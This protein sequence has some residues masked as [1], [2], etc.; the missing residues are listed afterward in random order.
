MSRA[1]GQSITE[2][3]S[4]ASYLLTTAHGPDGKTVEQL[5]VEVSH[6][7]KGIKHPESMPHL[8]DPNDQPFPQTIIEW[9]TWPKS[10]SEEPERPWSNLRPA[11]GPADEAS[12]HSKPPPE[13]SAL[14]KAKLLLDELVKLPTTEKATTV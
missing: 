2:A 14:A 1:D 11:P 5:L 7:L 13:L 4:H 3:T 8:E 9:Y 12:F 6:I 10:E